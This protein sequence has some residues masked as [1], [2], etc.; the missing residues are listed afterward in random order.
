[1]LSKGAV[2]LRLLPW[3]TLRSWGAYAALPLVGIITA[4]ILA[5]AL[6]PE[7][8]GQLA[9]M[10]QPLTVADAFAAI[11]VPAA[12]TF[13]VARGIHP[14]FLKGPAILLLLMST[15]V[16]AVVLFAYSSE[17]SKASGVPQHLLLALWLSTVLG[18]LIAYRRGTWQGLRRFGMLDTERA[19]AAALR[20]I[21]IL[22]LFVVGATTSFPF[23]VAY[24]TSGLLASML[25]LRR[26][27]EIP[28][29][30]TRRQ[31]NFSSGSFTRYSLLASLGTI[32]MTLN[33]RLDQAVLPAVVSS[34]ELGFYSVAVTVAEIPLI[35]T[36]VMNRNLL[37]EVSG[38][39]ARSTVVRTTI[40][41]CVGVFLACAVL[42]LLCPWLLPL[43]FG[44]AFEPA[45]PLV[46]LLL[47]GTF[48]GTIATAMSVI[49]TGRGRAGL[50]SIGPAVAAVSTVILLC[51]FLQ[52]MTVELAAW[53]AI[54]V[55]G[56]AVVVSAILLGKTRN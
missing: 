34:R 8:R 50:G 45:I 32:S 49:T 10:L 37:A 21:F 12:M 29:L 48:L 11:G 35:M 44:Q 22:G 24:V 47:M 51:F 18:A 40:L 4:P 23:A 3:G 6:G 55:Q 54:G 28:V 41:G 9:A 52:Q 7:G 15:L 25:L 53:I 46:R 17:V 16:V 36:T 5:R 43:A 42:A 20:V 38:G 2:R 31:N 26:L 1:V 13:Y 56:T 39:A 33:N 14:R 19:S 30:E 27:P